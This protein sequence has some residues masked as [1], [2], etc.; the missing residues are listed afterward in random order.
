MANSNVIHFNQEKRAAQIAN[1]RIARAAID[2]F[3]RLAGVHG[4]RWVTLGGITP[5]NKMF[6]VYSHDPCS[7]E[8]RLDVMFTEMQRR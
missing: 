2:E 4:C 1:E 7:G 6:T 8:P 5:D 3:V